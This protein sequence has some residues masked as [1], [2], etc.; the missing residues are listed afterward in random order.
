MSEK[1]YGPGWIDMILGRP[2]NP[3]EESDENQYDIF[4]EPVHFQS[5]SG[6]IKHLCGECGYV[7][8]EHAANCPVHLKFKE[9]EKKWANVEYQRP[10]GQCPSCPEPKEGPHRFSCAYGGARAT[11]VA[12]PVTRPDDG[13]FSV[14]P[15]YSNK[16]C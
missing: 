9:S 7:M 12:L 1:C 14:D 2:C 13:T 15:P 5:H 8:P 4:K 11:Q 6:H 16:P 3:N 10:E